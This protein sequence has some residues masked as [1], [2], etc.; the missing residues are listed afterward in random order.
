MHHLQSFP[1]N[2]IERVEVLADGAS[3]IYGSDAVAGVIN[4]IPKTNFDGFEISF[5]AGSPSEDGGDH[6][7]TGILFGISG[8]RG[9]F[10]AAISY[11]D[12]GDVDYQDRDWAQIPILGQLDV[13]GG[14]ILTLMGSGIPPEGRIL[15]PGAGVIFKADPVTNA[16]FQPYDTFCLSNTNGADGS[17]SLD[18]ILNQGHRFNYNDIPTG[19]SLINENQAV[20]FAG[21]GEYN[22]DN[23]MV[24]Y[25]STI[26]AHREGRL[27][28]TP[29][30]IQGAA[31][32]FT[33]LIQVPF[34]HPLL[35]TDARDLVLGARA[36]NC[37][38]LGDA[39]EEAACL[40]NP[41]F[42]MSWRGLDA[43]ARTF[44]YDS[45]TV[46]ATVGLRGTLKNDWEWDI[47][48]TVGHS[49]LFEVTK[50]QVNVGNLQIAVDPAACALVA[51]CPKDA[52]GDPTLNIFGRSPKTAEEIA[53]IT[54]D[55]IE[56]TSYD[57]VHFA[58]AISGEFGDLPAG[59]VGV[60]LGAEYRDESGGV[61]PS[62]IVQLGDS[63]G[64]FNSPTDGSYDVTELYAEFSIP[65]LEDAPGAEDLSLD[66]AFRWSDYNTF[67]DESTYKVAVSWAPIES[68]RFRGTVATGYR[69][70]NILE[71]FGGISDT[72]QSVVD[73]CTAPIADPNVQ[74]NCTAAG[75]PAGFVQ[76]A[77]QLK[78][79][80]GGN[81]SL[82]PETSDS[83][84]AGLVWEPDFAQLRVALDW[85]DV[86]VD[87]AIGTPDP[88]NIITT[89]YNSPAGDL[90]ALEC[91]RL[92]RG[93]AGD[94]VRFDLLNEN[95]AKIETS[96]IDMDV[97][98]STDV[99]FG[100]LEINWLVNYLDEW[101]QTLVSGVEED[102]TG[103]V[104]GAV[105]DWAAYPELRSN[106]RVR[107]IRDAWWVGLTYRYLDEMEAADV[108]GFGTLSPEADAVHYV[109]LDFGYEIGPWNLLAGVQNVSDEEPPY[110]T[111]VS[112]N[113]SDIYD[114]LGR[115]YYARAKYTIH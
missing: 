81:E 8:D 10:T 114:F 112:I 52:N 69:A 35:P 111:D 12:D 34:T 31:G 43:G 107:L 47:W 82:E 106:L 108:I 17:G 22:F 78:I 87:D 36:T 65:L 89:C 113:T 50:G 7:D 16:S 42:Q 53:Y 101:K 77:A 64:N 20:N 73:P 88:V 90:S 100:D 3:S 109:D 1:V 4:L 2:M 76:P 105:S 93:Q 28:F 71:L 40:A 38:A 92:G 67:G 61:Q 27:N 55:D 95:V 37:A 60:A 18:C 79:S 23:G 21:I 41:D 75:V 30:P 58:A 62:G 104:A 39:A 102:R 72:F 83:F 51:S 15:E 32:R 44:D 86:E 99:G 103:Q 66:V 98:Y 6:I 45:D 63:G 85:Y 46:A 97:T 94:I 9:F 49:E 80:A 26:V 91:G 56:D 57:M 24:G 33:D 110:V 14:Q 70:P 115:F 25:M 84:S 11:V 29:L 59:S 19:V 54:F 13:G 68:L 96:G 74:A 5:G 48:A